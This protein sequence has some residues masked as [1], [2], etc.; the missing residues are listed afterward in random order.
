MSGKCEI[1]WEYGEITWRSWSWKQ[2]TLSIHSRP[3]IFYSNPLCLTGYLNDW[4]IL[5]CSRI[6]NRSQLTTWCLACRTQIESPLDISSA[7]HML[8]IKTICKTQY[9][10]RYNCIWFYNLFMIKS[11]DAYREDT[12]IQMCFYRNRPLLVFKQSSLNLIKRLRALTLP[13]CNYILNETNTLC[14]SHL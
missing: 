13:D 2:L 1:F 9:R 4:T 3:S 12:N 14:R 6:I 8:Q 5:L 10:S 11:S 7:T